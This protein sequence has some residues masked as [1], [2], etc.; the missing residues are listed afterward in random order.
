MNGTDLI[1]EQCL[2]GVDLIEAGSGFRIGSPAFDFVSVARDGD[3]WTSVD[4]AHGLIVESSLRR[5]GD[6]LVIEH[7]LTNIGDGLPRRST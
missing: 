3:R 6:A 2:P 4:R 7:R 5:Q 1:R